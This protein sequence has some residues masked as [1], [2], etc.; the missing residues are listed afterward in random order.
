MIKDHGGLS[1]EEMF[2]QMERRKHHLCKANLRYEAGT[3][4]E[5]IWILP[6]T[7]DD[8]RLWNGTSRGE[9][10]YGW[11]CN[12]PICPDVQ[13]GSKVA[14]LTNGSKR[15][16]SQDIASSDEEYETTKRQLAGR[17]AS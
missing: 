1:E 5:G 12:N 3:N 13:F 6:C 16:Y 7:A 10:L 15:P 11:L 9:V 2:Q 17:Q 8:V 14:F 4:G